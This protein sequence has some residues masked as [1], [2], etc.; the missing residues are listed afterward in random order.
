MRPNILLCVPFYGLSEYKLKCEAR[1]HTSREHRLGFLPLVFF[2]EHDYQRHAA[3]SDSLLPRSTTIIYQP[4]ARVVGCDS[5]SSII[6]L[7]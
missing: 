5:T 3:R 1:A 6:G 4:Q 2:S 7:V